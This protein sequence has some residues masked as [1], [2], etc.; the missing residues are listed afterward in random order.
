MIT[1][2]IASKTNKNISIKKHKTKKTKKYPQ[3]I[4]INNN[5]YKIIKQLGNGMFG[6]VYLVS[7]NNIKYAYKIEHIDKKEYNNYKKNKKCNIKNELDFSTKFANN[8]P[9]QFIQLIDFDF[10]KKCNHKQ[11]YSFQSYSIKLTKKTFGEQSVSNFKKLANSPYCSRKIY[12]LIDT[13]FDKLKDTDKFN[14]KE[15]Y[16]LLIQ[17]YYSIFLMHANGYV[18]GDLNMGN[19]GVVNTTEKYITIFN[20]QIPTYGRIYKMI[21]YGIILNESN[22]KNTK[23]LKQIYENAK[24]TQISMV[25]ILKNVLFYEKSLLKIQQIS[26][27]NF[28]KKN[29]VDNKI[30]YENFTKLEEFKIISNYTNDIQIQ[31]F[32]LNLL[33]PELYKKIVFKQNIKQDIQHKPTLP[34]EDILFIIKTDTNLKKIIEYFIN[35]LI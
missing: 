2:K 19:I 13:S 31:Y 33:Y 22:Y 34:L 29:I 9:N 27:Y 8:Y 7:H 17:L 18:H 15:L 30:T 16:S 6:T 20:K 32:L 21:D 1:K 28:I 11:T 10:I 3:D 26:Y 4:I 35:K 23:Q 24:L 5:T 12:T 25:R 14:H